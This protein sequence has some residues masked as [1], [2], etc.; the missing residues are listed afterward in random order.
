M[1]VALAFAVLLLAGCSSPPPDPAPVAEPPVEE[2]MIDDTVVVFA[3]TYY[4]EVDKDIPTVTMVVPPGGDKLRVSQET[5]VTDLPCGAAIGTPQTPLE[6]NVVLTSPSG[7]VTVMPAGGVPCSA[8][9][10]VSMSGGVAELEPEV[11]EWSIAFEGRGTGAKIKLVVTLE[12]PE[13]DEDD[14]D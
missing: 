7:E 4:Y 11:G 12:P 10:L 2:P 8:V 1:R 6:A 14:D 9:I 5:M 3:E 13:G